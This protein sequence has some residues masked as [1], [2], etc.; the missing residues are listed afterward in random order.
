MKKTVSLK[1]N[2]EFV[3]AYKKGKFFVGRYLVV[4]VLK[5]RLGINRLGITANKKVGKSVRRNR[6]KR[7]IRENYRF[8][9]D[10]ISGGYDI[11]F[12]ARN[13]DKEYGFSEIRR[14]MKFLLKKMQVFDRGDQNG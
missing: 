14:E 6:V 7:L 9:E 2:Y 8:Y 12:V 5:N 4:Y 10:S 13:P 1:K 11:V 3:R